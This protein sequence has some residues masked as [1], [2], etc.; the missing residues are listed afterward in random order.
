MIGNN[1]YGEKMKG[2]LDEVRIYDR[3]LSANE[4][5]QL[6]AM[7]ALAPAITPAPPRSS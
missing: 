6:Y 1:P 5:A 4:V 2:W 7:E 3:A